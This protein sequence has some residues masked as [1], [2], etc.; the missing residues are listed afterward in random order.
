MADDQTSPV[1]LL[2]PFHGEPPPA[3]AWFK[4]AIAQAPERST[5]AVDGANIELLT[6]GEIGKPGLLFL[7]GNGAPRRLVELHRA[8]LRQRL[9]GGGDLVVGHG[10]ERLARGLQRRTVR[11]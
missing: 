2:A 5:I 7:H 1:S 9:A 6:W 4:G 10:R 8:V 3:P 11:D